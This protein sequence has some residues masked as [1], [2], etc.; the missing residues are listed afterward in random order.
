MGCILKG[1]GGLYSR[2]RVGAVL[3]AA[4]EGSRLGGRPKCLLELGGVPLVR[5]QLIALSG[6]GVDELVVVLGHH[7]QRIEP[8]VAEFPVTLVRNPHP[9]Q[10]QASSTRVGLQALA[11]VDCVLVALA[12]QPLL[13]AQDVAD[14]IKAY[15]QRPEGIELVQP[16]VDGQPGN[17]LVFSA[18]VREQILA[19]PGDVACRRW[20]E[21]HAGQVL[22]WPTANRRYAVDID[23][24]QDI[25]E[26]AQRTGHRLRW[27][28]DLAPA[29]VQP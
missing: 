26:L 11:A 28:R 23:T 8:V 6:G 7:A 1:G 14:L 21:R 2:L 3:L 22:R 24:E 25:E 12:D 20:Q 4:G 13:H 29:A 19:G 17:P 18:A 5:R 27:P 15:K 16:Q 9:E 10:G